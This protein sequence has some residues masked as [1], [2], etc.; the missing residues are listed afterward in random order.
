MAEH[1][2]HARCEKAREQLRGGK[3]DRAIAHCRAL[4][5]LHPK[6]VPAYTIM[7]EAYLAKGEHAEAANLF[8]RT[9]GADPEATIPYAGLGLIYEERGLLEEAIW[10][11][12]RAFEL[13]PYNKEIR[14]SLLDLYTQRDAVPPPRR[15]LNRA[16]LARIYMSGHLYDRAISELRDL[17]RE[18]PMRIDLRVALAEALW[19]DARCEGAA[20]VCQGILDLAPNCLNANLILG[21]IWLRDE[22]REPEGRALLERAQMLDPE[23][24]TAQRMFGARS[25]LAPHIVP[26]PPHLTED[27]DRADQLEQSEQIDQTSDIEPATPIEPAVETEVALDAEGPPLEVSLPLEDVVAPL[28]EMAKLAEEGI[29]S[30]QEETVAGTSTDLWPESTADVL[31]QA[32][33]IGLPGTVDES[34]WKPE[35]E[36]EALDFY[37]AKDQAGIARIENLR[38]QVLSDPENHTARLKLARA[39]WQRDELNQALEQYEPIVGEASEV[40]GKAIADLEEITS[41]QPGNL[42]ALELLAQAYAQADRPADALPIYQQLY[43]QLRG[44]APH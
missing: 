21:E 28:E 39:C 24:A 35:V 22:E 20:V 32:G 17:L 42:L 12:E 6:Y 10:Q 8:R 1:N 41:Q 16:A 11:L 43:S 2:L 25:P 3:Y 31:I 30:V 19:H 9:L 15:K 33:E 36:E 27:I 40:L 29:G 14:A 5:M 38:E 18:D 7:G 13:T 4:L 26:V 37:V 44:Q 34:E 23:N